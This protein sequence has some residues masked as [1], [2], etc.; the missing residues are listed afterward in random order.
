LGFA[1]RAITYAD[2]WPKSTAHTAARH[3]PRH[4][5]IMQIKKTPA[6]HDCL[7]G[8]PSSSLLYNGHCSPPPPPLVDLAPDDHD[9]CQKEEEAYSAHD[10]LVL[11]HPPP[12]CG[13]Q[14][15]CLGAGM[16]RDAGLGVEGVDER[17]MVRATA[18]TGMSPTDLPSPPPLQSMPLPCAATTT[19]PCFFDDDSLQCH[20]MSPSCAP[21][22]STPPP[23]APTHP[24]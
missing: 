15:A 12:H 14:L 3:L 17:V 21:P 23:P 16:Q 1:P 20:G 10:D 22:S 8:S 13:Q 5:A 19:L 2:T 11:N 4:K 24:P 6:S 9:D 18:C 7:R